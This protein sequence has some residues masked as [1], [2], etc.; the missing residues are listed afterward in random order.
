MIKP[1][2]IQQAE[3]VSIV[4][5]LASRGI[6]PVKAVGPEL[7]YYSPLREEKNASFFV[8]QTKNVFHDFTNDDH[9]GNTIRLVQLLEQ[10]NFPQAVAKLLEY[11][12]E[13]LKEYAPLFLSAT[14][15]KAAIKPQTDIAPLTNP[16]LLNYVRERAI[17]HSIATKYLKEVTTTV[18][19]STYFS[20]GFGIDSGGFAV[21]NKYFQGWEGE[22]D[23]TTFDLRCRTVVAVFEGFFD[24]LSALVFYGLEAPRMPTVI[25]N[26]TANRKKS[27]Y[28]L[29]QFEQ[30]NCF[31]DRDQAG[32]DCLRL[33]SN[34]EGLNVKDC[35]TLY[36]GFKDFNEF[37][38]SK[39]TKMVS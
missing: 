32:R 33:L 29:R 15:S 30:V 31:L 11:Q 34:V 14:E 2:L 36:A 9:K 5:Y 10:C 13:P 23:I 24:F 27:I 19:G 8:N 12:G 6:E 3:A 25:L 20:V 4:D 1:E 17:P 38:M 26:S 7:V 37:L 22:P 35:S 28:Y 16:V 21:R 18:K 39:Q